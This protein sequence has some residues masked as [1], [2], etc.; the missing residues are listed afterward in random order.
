MRYLL[1]PVKRADVIEGIDARGQA[2]ME[3]EDLVLNER[4]ERK[5]IEEVGEVFPDVGI[6]VLAQA[7]VVEAIDLCDLT[8]LVIATEDGDALG[9]S[10]LKSN[11]KGDGLNR[12]VA[13]INVIAHEEVV[14]VG[15][16]S[17]NLE[18][19]H[20]VMELTMYITTNGYGAFHWLDVGLV[21]Q[22]L[23]S[24]F[25]QSLHVSLGELLAIH[26]GCDP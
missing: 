7:F 21:L 2:A 1:Y 11:E 26:Q 17:S 14:G 19:L 23:A 25:A 9:V 8:R 5:V 4:S 12:E 10:D 16:R 24:L 18:Q 22:H 6:A 13:A 20:Q 3:T 15:V